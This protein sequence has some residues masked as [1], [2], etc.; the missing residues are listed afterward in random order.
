MS[1]TLDLKQLERRVYRETVQDGIVE[2]L[3]GCLLMVGGAAIADA[4]AMEAF[5]VPGVI[6]MLFMWRALEALK[7]RFIYPR[8]GKAVLRQVKPESMVSR[9]LLFIVATAAL[10]P[11]SL[12]LLGRL[13]VAEWY[14]W[15]PLWIGFCLIGAMAH[16]Y[17]RSR[18]PRLIVYAIVGLGAGF[19]AGSLRLP[20]KMD[21]IALYLI[22]MGLLLAAVGAVMLVRFLRSYPIA[23]QEAADD[24]HE[25]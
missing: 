2:I 11:L 12:A 19:A 22:C 9:I 23:P 3:I 4:N 10:V 7:R 15:L 14:R 18:S 21:N 20:G 1:Q 25:G 17:S 13:T 8:L 5:A 16:L 24:Q 6:G